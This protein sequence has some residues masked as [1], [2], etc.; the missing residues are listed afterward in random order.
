MNDLINENGLLHFLLEHI[1]RDNTLLLAIRNECF[2]I[3]YRGGNLLKVSRNSNSTCN[4]FFD[5]SYNKTGIY[6]PD[7]P[8]TIKKPDDVQAWIMAFPYLKVIMDS[9]FADHNKPEKEFQ[10]LIARENNFSSISNETEYFITDIE[11][12]DS[13]LSARFDM[14]AV[15]WPASGR[16]DGNKY[17]VAL[18]E[19]KYGDNALAGNAGIVKHLKDFDLFVSDTNRYKL[20]LDTIRS[21]FTQLDQ[22]GLLRYNHPAKGTKLKLNIE[23][24]PEVVFVFANH[25][26][27]STKLLNILG[28]PWVKQFTESAKFNLKFFVSSFVGYAFHT[29]CMYPLTDF[30]QLLQKQAELGKGRIYY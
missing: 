27:R 29:H 30:L 8:T 16:K 24:I 26:P 25:N 12:S 21:Q 2:N 7:L 15:K 11:F 9:Y 28:D 4:F 10:Q 3:Y 14:L 23:L 5:R 20:L 17:Q 18:I 19:V 22:L 13:D 6:L 1:K